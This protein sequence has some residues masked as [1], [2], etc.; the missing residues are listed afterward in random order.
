LALAVFAW[1]F[2]QC[3]RACGAGLDTAQDLYRSG[4]YEQCL[5]SSRRAIEDGSEG[6]QWRELAVQSLMALGRYDQAAKEMDAAILDLPANIP[7]MKLAHTAYLHSGHTARAREVLTWIYDVA[8][9]RGVASRNARALVA[10]GETLL[11][12]GAE[13]KVVLDDFYNGA[14]QADP[15][16]LEAYLA[17]GALALA[18][19]DYDLAAGQYRRAL[20]SQGDHPDVHCGLARAFYPSDRRAM[21]QSLDAAL[22]LNPRHAPSLILLAEHQIDCEDYDAAAVSLDRVIAVNPWHPEAWAYK[23]L[24]AHLANDPNAAQGHRDRALKFWSTNPRVDH[25]IGAKLS[26]KYR[27]EEGARFQRQA[28]LFDPAFQQARIQLAED[29]LRLG[30]EREGWALAEEVHTQDPYNVT[31]YNLVSLRDRLSEFRTLTDEGL[32]VRMD[33]R[34]AAVYGD[35]VVRLLKEAWIGLCGRYGLHLDGPVTVELFPNQ[36]DFA[37]RTFGMPGVE[38][39]LGVCF[40]K[41]I[42]ANSPKAA[43]VHNWEAMLWHEFAHVVTLHLTANKMPRWLSEGMS[44][45][46]EWQRDP[47]WGQRITPAYRKMIL[48]EDLV[49]VSELSG[50]FMS[51]PS[52]VHLQFAYLESALAVEFLVERYGMP[53]LKGILADLA[54]GDPIN[55]AIARHA[56]PLQEVDTQFA[57]FARAR[58]RD[59]ARDVDWDEPDQGQVD[60]TDPNAVAQWLGRHPNSLWGLTAQAICLVA[61]RRWEEA[62]V[63]LNKLISLYPQY[64]GEGN[65]YQLLAQVHRQLGQTDQEQQVLSRLAAL[66]CDA[67]EAYTRLMEIAVDRKDW[68]EVVDQA[69]RVLAVNPMMGAVYRVMGQAHEGLGQEGQAVESYARLLRLDPADPAEVH[70]RLAGLLRRTDP[71]AAKRHVLESLADAPRFREGHRLLLEI[72]REGPVSSPQGGQP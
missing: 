6:A 56:A 68:R 69:G 18:K 12:L 24:L 19:Q 49:P 8:R 11:L 63:P 55:N 20:R 7:L 23:S 40:G 70:Y 13:P 2:A 10:L 71:A 5:E 60:P 29:L 50:A 34:E 16:C 17:T 28:L 31:A 72:L 52:P 15:N 1:S 54:K 38:G 48:G 3:G 41:V 43:P 32:I 61:D 30:Q 39:F 66:S 22:H 36:Q 33:P 62:K 25:L 9:A 59:V 26:Q 53:A 57:A 44:V 58:A 4:Q 37:V 51:P 67:A 21:G 27:F 64:T 42:T 47:V 35:R 45:Y 14:I 65:P 46:E